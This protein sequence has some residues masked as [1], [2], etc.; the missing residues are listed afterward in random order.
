MHIEFIFY[1][2]VG[3]SIT[4]T[5]VNGSIFDS[6]RNWLLVMA[7]LFGRLVTCVRCLGFWVGFFLFSFLT[8][9]NCI[10]AVLPGLPEWL[11]SFVMPFVQSGFG[12]IVESIV[13]FLI[14]ERTV[15][16]YEA[17]KTGNEQG[18]DHHGSDQ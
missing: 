14:K 17:R 18:T 12:V 15:N 11:N 4:S 2:F 5:I 8:V 6:L 3:W 16:I 10:G 1:L 13:I 7:P 9:E